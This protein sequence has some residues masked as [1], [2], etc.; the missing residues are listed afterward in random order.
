MLA[1]QK[2]CILLYCSDDTALFWSDNWTSDLLMIKFPRIHSFGIDKL[3][4]VKDILDMDDPIDVFRLP[5]STQAFEE[6]HEYNHLINQTRS[7]R[8]ADVNDLWSYSWGTHFS[9]SKIYKLNF[10]HIQAP[11]FSPWIWKSKCTPKI[12]SFSCLL[13]MVLKVTRLS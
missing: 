5:L 8:N 9:A 1:I 12:K 2:N 10:E 3:A 4:L 11:I 13:A 7:T 6:L